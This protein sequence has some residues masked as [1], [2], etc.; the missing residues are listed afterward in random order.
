HPISHLDLMTTACALA[1]VTPDARRPLDGVNL[2]SVLK[3][4]ET[5][6]VREEFYFRI[7]ETWAL[8][9]GDYKLILPTGAKR[10]ELYHIPSDLTESHDLAAAHPEIVKQLQ[11]RF[12]ALSAQMAAPAWP[13]PPAPKAGL[14]R[15]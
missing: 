15:E 7:G 10:P 2:T 8:R 14:T 6:R 9:R 11:A 3:G 4:E 12:D 1:G 5:G 13:Y